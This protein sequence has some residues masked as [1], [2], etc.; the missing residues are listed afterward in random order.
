VPN[1]TFDVPQYQ[2]TSFGGTFFFQFQQTTKGEAAYILQ[3]FAVEHDG[4]VNVLF[5]YLEIL[6]KL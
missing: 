2:P 3:V 6:D 4:F 1:F 5:K